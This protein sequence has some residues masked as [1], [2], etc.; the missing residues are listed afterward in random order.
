MSNEIIFPQLNFNGSGYYSL[1]ESYTMAIAELSG[2]IELI[3]RPHGR[4]YDSDESFAEALAQYDEWIHSSTKI[5]RSMKA[6]CR[7]ISVQN[8][9]AKNV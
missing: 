2:A 1:Y 3:P 4:D 6:I 5:V 9:K 8:R 7:D